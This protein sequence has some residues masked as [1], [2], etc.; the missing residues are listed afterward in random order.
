MAHR[1]RRSRLLRVLRVGW[2]LLVAAVVADAVYLAAIWPD[3]ETLAQ[4]PV[5]E[6]SFIRQYRDARGRDPSLPPLQWQPVPLSRIP[7]HVRRAVIVAEDSRFHEHHG[8]DF[9]ALEAAMRVNWARR[10][11]AFGASTI[12]QQTVKNLYLSRS[13][14]LLRKW[15]EAVLTLA[16][17]R[18]LDKQ[19]ILE[20]YLNVVE[21]GR[22]IYGVEAAS[23]HY[24]G[25]SVS[26]VT[27]RQAAELAATLPSPVD[28][29][30]ASRTP[31][32]RRHA[33][34][35]HARLKQVLAQ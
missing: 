28:A 18:H 31:F 35:V 23:R 29:N 15:H 1:R 17:E 30:P 4:G 26:S 20:I 9:E 2:W 6:S 5:P 34:T 19:R 8:I 32:F 11:F 21:L 10:R 3:F 14:D 7:G 22:G 33:D 16:M 13:R 12:S 27:V 25:R 24:W